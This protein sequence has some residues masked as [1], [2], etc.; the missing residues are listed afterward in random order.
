MTA[1]D[2]QS[3][4]AQVRA[5]AD[6]K[7]RVLREIVETHTALTNDR[8]EFLVADAERVRQLNALV[9]EARSAGF[10]PKTL[11]PFTVEHLSSSRPAGSKSG[12]R[13]R[14]TKKAESEHVSAPAAGSETRTPQ[15]DAS[16]QSVPHFESTDRD[17]ISA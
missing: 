5:E 4:E 3:L 16:G 2:F 14:R 7:V 11:K 12:T 6:H 10:D 9:S 13:R 1:V 15:G 8:D 17:A